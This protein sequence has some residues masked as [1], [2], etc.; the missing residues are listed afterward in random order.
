MPTLELCLE[1]ALPPHHFDDYVQSELTPICVLE[2]MPTY[3]E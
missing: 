3:R 2:Q 1:Q